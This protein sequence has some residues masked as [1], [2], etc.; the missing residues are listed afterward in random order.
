MTDLT[1]QSLGRYQILERL[2]EGGMAVVYK[3]YDTRLES[4]VAVKIIRTEN[5]APSILTRALKR[6]ER[7]AKSLAKLTHANIVRVLDYGEHEGKPFL[8]MPYLPGGT[9]KQRLQGRQMPYQEAVRILIPIC[10]A[11]EYA[12]EQGMIHR[13]VKP[14]NILITQSGDPMLTD[15]GIAKIIDEEAT[16][17]LTGTSS[18]IGTPEY[19]AP[20]QITSKNVDHR[21]DIYALGIVFYEMVTGRRPFR[22]DTPM[23]VLFKHA[24]E[25]LPRPKQFAPS[26]PDEIEKILFKALTKKPEDRYQSMSEMVHTLENIFSRQDKALAKGYGARPTRENVKSLSP[27][28]GGVSGRVP[29]WLTGIPIGIVI[30]IIGL[31]LF[32][33]WPS[34]PLDV[35]RTPAPSATTLPRPTASS[36]RPA[37]R[38]TLIPPTISRVTPTSTPNILIAY[39][40]LN[41]VRLREGPDLQFKHVSEYDVGAE[42][43]L[44]A[45]Y[46]AWFQV[47]CFDGKQGWLAL[48]WLT[49]SSSLDLD[50]LRTVSPSELPPACKKYSC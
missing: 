2:G 5:L 13:D 33:A 16:M 34:A 17:D 30:T 11:L 9:L 29:L 22:A 10:R 18:T 43:V 24:S 49:I 36:T 46:K 37:P 45:R 25:P 39:V 41:N 35:T 14:S 44:I 7:E 50:S 31:L 32:R 3:A 1:G 15:F 8:V 38:A 20:E 6:F 12:H 26:L 47:Q 27:Q 28:S 21:A 40:K 42:C 4:E 19:M 23:A 48:D